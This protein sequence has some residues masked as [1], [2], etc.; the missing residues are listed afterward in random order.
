MK[1]LARGGSMESRL[2]REH[3]RGAS[4]VNEFWDI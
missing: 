3:A 1:S 2:D 4:Q